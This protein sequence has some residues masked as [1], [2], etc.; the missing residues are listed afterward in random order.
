MPKDIQKV[1]KSAAKETQKA[2]YKKAAELENSLLVDLK[3][4]GMKV[5]KANHK[6][7]VDA[8]GPI[9]DQFSTSVNGAFGMLSQINTLG[10]GL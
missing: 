2:T 6:S 5:N 10:E 3:K 7:F 4:S 9:Y 1:L 8:S